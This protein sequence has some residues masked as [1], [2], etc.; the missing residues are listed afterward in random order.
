V[1]E[2][3]GNLM[4]PDTAP[5]HLSQRTARILRRAACLLALLPAAVLAQDFRLPNLP[6]SVK[7]AVI[8][9]MGVGT[10]RQ[11][12]VSRQMARFHEVFP[13]D[14]VI[15]VGDNIYGGQGPRDLEQKFE[16]PYRA[17]LDAGVSFHASLGN[18]DDP[19]NRFYPLWNMN[20]QRYYTFARQHVRFFALDTTDLDP[21]QL[22]WLDRELG[23]AREPWKIVYFHHPLYS[24]ASRHGSQMPLR[25]M[26]EPLFIRHRVHVVF[27]GHDHVYERVKPQHGIHHFVVGAGGQL[28]P[29]NLRPSVLTAAGF[30]RDQSFLLAEIHGDTMS[31]QAV[32]RLGGVIDL[33]TIPRR[34]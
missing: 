5:P 29:G 20:G 32:T 22:A 24:A 30:D 15:T 25:V 1:A 19:Q 4:A 26:L 34:P 8:G 23:R 18:H 13:F 2:V 7:F 6:G 17:L 3:A 12:D 33:A 14:L 21:D 11:Y 28:R 16:R 31:I 9:D 10:A 27:A